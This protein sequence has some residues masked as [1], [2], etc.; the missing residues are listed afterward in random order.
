MAIH[1][2]NVVFSRVRPLNLSDIL[3]AY[4]G[5][6]T[7]LFAVMGGRTA[8]IRTV[9]VH[10]RS[11]PSRR[12][13][14][15]AKSPGIAPMETRARWYSTRAVGYSKNGI[16]SV[17]SWKIGGYRCRRTTLH[18]TTGKMKRWTRCANLGSAVWIA[19]STLVTATIMVMMVIGDWFSMTNRTIRV[20]KLIIFFC[21]HSDSNQIL[22][23]YL[24]WQLSAWVSL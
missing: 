10:T 19:R 21:L 23:I 20:N 7:P 2:V 18:P 14:H 15:S 8:L 11:L 5:F 1:R 9:S 16:E 12:T 3:T 6:E 4:R 24:F 22:F 17:E 13:S